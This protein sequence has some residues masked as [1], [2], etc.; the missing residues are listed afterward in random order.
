MAYM[1]ALQSTH[2]S[3]MHFVLITECVLFLVLETM[4][5]VYLVYHLNKWGSDGRSY[6][7][8]EEEERH[9]R[10]EDKRRGKPKKLTCLLRIKSGILSLH[11]NYL[12]PHFVK[13]K[14]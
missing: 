12:R 14:T 8:D 6:S 4:A 13:Q 11:Q 5:K 9:R 1:L 2:Y 3:V 7:D 10:L